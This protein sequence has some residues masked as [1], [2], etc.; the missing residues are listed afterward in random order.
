MPA[1]PKD[2]LPGLALRLRDHVGQ[3]LERRI[4]AHQQDIGRR[5]QQRNRREILEGVVGKFRIQ[6]RI[7]GVAA[8]HDDQR[9][10]VG[11]RGH[12]R[13][14]GD[15]AARARPVFDDDGLAPLPGD[16]IAQRAR[17]DID[18]AAGR[19]GH[20]NM[21]G[22]WTE[23]AAAPMPRRDA[24]SPPRSSHPRPPATN[25]APERA[26]PKPPSRSSCYRS[27]RTP[28]LRP[29]IVAERRSR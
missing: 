9:V 2:R 7:G 23:T 25:N 20:E 22:L 16:H 6:E 11:R 29:R 8:G 3:R 26:V 15:H 21:H 19:I 4:G 1:W 13:L 27:Y 18:P 17:Q 10:A 12:Q 24:T 5:G 28:A 14:R